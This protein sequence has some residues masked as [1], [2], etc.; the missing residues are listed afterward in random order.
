ML[1]QV[2][3]Y[4]GVLIWIFGRNRRSGF[5]PE[6]EDLLVGLGLVCLVAAFA[7]VGSKLPFANVASNKKRIELPVDP[8]SICVTFL[9]LIF[10]AFY[11]I[12]SNDTFATPQTFFVVAGTA[13]LAS[14]FREQPERRV[15]TLVSLFL[16][17]GIFMF[18]FYEYEVQKPPH[19]LGK[20]NGDM[21]IGGVWIMLPCA[22][23]IWTA[24]H[25][26]TSSKMA[27][28]GLIFVALGSLAAT[29]ILSLFFG[30]LSLWLCMLIPVLTAGFRLLDYLESRS[31]V[32]AE[33]VAEAS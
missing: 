1:A 3:A 11:E 26:A 27:L 2:V 18:A 33:P 6:L 8:I 10:I 31:E 29:F 22:L 24:V 23:G 25:E 20:T 19:T 7:L 15:R 17:A 32:S 30:V 14:V 9:A 16:I 12:M 28:F 13:I 4:S 21:F 5:T